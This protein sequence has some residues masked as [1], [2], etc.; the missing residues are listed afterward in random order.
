MPVHYRTDGPIGIFTLE[1]GAVNPTTPAMHKELHAALTA[2]LRDPA[3]RCGILTGAGERAFCAGDDI[4][5][6][7]R[8]ACRAAARSSL[9]A[10]VGRRGAARLLMVARRAGELPP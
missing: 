6:P 5:T 10:C 4:K 9:A 3:I 7:R 8:S 1:N 2:F